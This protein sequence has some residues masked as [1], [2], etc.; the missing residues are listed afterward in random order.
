M[1]VLTKQ[2]NQGSIRQPITL[3]VSFFTLDA[4]RYSAFLSIATSFKSSISYI[5]SEAKK[6]LKSL[7]SYI[8][9]ELGS[10]QYNGPYAVP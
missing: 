10:R 1:P 2:L 5:Y 8:Y 7:V 9:L 6:N 4:S 3:K